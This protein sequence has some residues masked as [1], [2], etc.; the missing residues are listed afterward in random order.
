MENFIRE[1]QI[2]SN[3]CDQLIRYIHRNPEK[4]FEGRSSIGVNKAV[5]DSIDTDLD[6]D[7][8]LYKDYVKEIQECFDKYC[9]D[10]PSIHNSPP[11]GIVEGINL[12]W[13]KPEGG[14][15]VWHCERSVSPEPDIKNGRML[16]WITY[17]NDVP[18]AGTEFKYYPELEVEAVKGKT[19][20]WPVDWTHTHRGRVSRTHNKYIA[21]GWMNFINLAD[22]NQIIE[23]YDKQNQQVDSQQVKEPVQYIDE[24]M[25]IEKGGLGEMESFESEEQPKYEWP[26]LEKTTNNDRF[27][28]DT[29]EYN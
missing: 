27:V 28:S 18:N 24:N 26:Y 21:T 13:Y 7:S 25:G 29:T 14:Y 20:I 15:Y 19:I 16:V 22:E 2:D 5:K 23:G 3:L 6:R 10:F 4:N 9:D 12:Q 11:W 1:Y 17:L 8:S